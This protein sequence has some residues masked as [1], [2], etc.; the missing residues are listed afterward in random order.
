MP[1]RSISKLVKTGGLLSDK[2]NEFAK[3]SATDRLV[4]V[5]I[6]CNNRTELKTWLIYTSQNYT[7]SG[8]RIDVEKLLEDINKFERYANTMDRG[9]GD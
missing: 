8:V 2:S 3:L 1:S 4:C 6:L 5:D 7:S 9:I